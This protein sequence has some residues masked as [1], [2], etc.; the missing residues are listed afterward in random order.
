MLLDKYDQIYAALDCDLNSQP[1]SLAQSVAAESLRTSFFKKN[2]DVVAPDAGEKAKKLFGDMNRR[3][4][5]WRLP[6][7]HE[8]EAQI[9]GT[10]KA[11][12]A[13]MV[14]EPN[15]LSCQNTFS[16]DVIT[17]MG[18][19]GPGASVGTRH[20]SYVGK[21]GDSALTGSNRFLLDAWDRYVES[22]HLTLGAEKQ[23]RAKHGL[24][25]LV[26]GSNL[27]TVP[28]NRTID[29]TI[30]TEPSI[31]MFFQKGLANVLVRAVKIKTGLCLEKQQDKAKR[32]A[33]IG[34]RTGRFGTLDLSSA[35]DTVSLRL[36]HQLFPRQFCA[37][38]NATRVKY[39]ADA[40]VYHKLYMA[41]TMGCGWTFI[42]QTMIFTS[43]VLAS[44][45]VLGIKVNYPRARG[46]GNFS[47]FGDDIIVDA[48]AYNVVF[49]MLEKLGFIP[50][51]EKSFNSGFFR[52]SCGGDYYA[53]SDVRGVYNKS[54]QTPHTVC[55]SVNLLMVWSARHNIA[56]P[57]TIGALLSLVPKAPYILPLRNFSV[58]DGVWSPSLLGPD[59]ARWPRKN[60]GG[61]TVTV[62]RPRGASSSVMDDDC[63]LP[64]DAVLLAALKGAL[65]RG[66]YPIRLN[67]GE[68]R[69]ERRRVFVSSAH[70]NVSY[71]DDARSLDVF[72]KGL[73]QDTFYRYLDFYV[74]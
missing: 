35:S 17:A 54:L 72:L 12:L 65:R 32:L 44:Y 38:L 60:R 29:R 23:R 22:N 73:D 53:G 1:F 28:K 71:E 11:I 14:L 66:R 61:W 8:H 55:S 63:T 51:P 20:V 50:N 39:Y 67:N 69:Y 6:R 41:G 10:M 13:D 74:G 21:C 68:T 15:R 24:P 9:L 48:K 70:W 40:G 33:A 49:S 34:S 5:K 43:L 59:R 52:E 27:T 56:L 3:C 26:K 4:Q 64:G 31:N 30:A 36:V 18:D 2:V 25:R 19:F 16:W 7:L 46:V 45:S 47:V 62:L 57:H 58:A 42:L 37:L